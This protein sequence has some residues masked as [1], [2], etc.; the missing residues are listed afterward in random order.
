V[1]PDKPINFG[2]GDANCAFPGTSQLDVGD[3]A[4]REPHPNGGFFDSQ[5]LS[6][7]RDREHRSLFFAVVVFG[8]PMV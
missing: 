1:V 8:S 3:T 7:L 2:L 4:L 5:T 6:E